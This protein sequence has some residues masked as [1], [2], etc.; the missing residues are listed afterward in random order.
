MKTDITLEDLTFRQLEAIIRWNEN[1]NDTLADCEGY[2]AED[3]RETVAQYLVDS[4]CS[5]YELIRDAKL[6]VNNQNAR[7]VAR[8]IGNDVQMVLVRIVI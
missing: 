7:L 8:G 5:L 2:D 4:E 1:G 6:S 3:L